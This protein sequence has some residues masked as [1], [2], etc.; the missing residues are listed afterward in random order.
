MAGLWDEV[1]QPLILSF[2]GEKSGLVTPV[3][4]MGGKLHSLW[5]GEGKGQKEAPQLF[6]SFQIDHKL[7][8]RQQTGSN[9]S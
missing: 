7:Q 4:V 1:A 5:G 9:C 6:R 8:D 3:T 2:W